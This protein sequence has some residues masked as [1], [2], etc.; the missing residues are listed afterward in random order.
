MRARTATRG[1][2][3]GTRARTR[4][5]VGGALAAA[6]AATLMSTP[7][8]A[9]PGAP[10][11]PA[12][13][14]DATQR[15]LDELVRQGTPGVIA[16]ISS[17]HRVWNGVA[18]VADRATGQPRTANERFRAASI[19]KTFVAAVLLD[20]EADGLLSL[21]DTVEKWLPGVVR[22]NGNDGRNITV[23]QLL[24][25]SSGLRE[26]M[27]DPEYQRKFFTKEFLKSRYETWPPLK[28]VGV[29]LSHRPDFAPGERHS[30]SNTGY[31]LAAMIIEKVSGNSYAG[32]VRKRVLKP[33]GLR[34]TTQ[35]GNRVTIPGPHARMYSALGGDPRT[36]EVYDVTEQNGSQA[37]GDGDV[38]STTGDL[39]RF[40]RGLLGG[41]LLP[42][43]QLAEMKR[44]LPNAGAVESYDSYGLGLYSYRTACGTKVYGHSG[45]AAGGGSEVV[46]TEDGRRS[47]ALNV[48]SDWVLPRSVVDA[49]FCG[50]GRGGTS[51]D[52]KSLDRKSAAGAA[53]SGERAALGRARAERSSTG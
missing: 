8:Q 38:I 16:Q 28:T 1:R 26:Y 21:D 48:N 25:H 46:A 29:G 11:G 5:A 35:P 19:T 44:M 23:R 12:A 30:Y 53:G 50:G 33:L 49:A 32:E 41:E 18:G 20:Q 3:T 10:S 36:D 42:P 9:A 22:G 37:F 27:S 39:N 34:H 52:G 43:R 24:N 7:A 40:L 15:A 14:Y 47:V 31:V 17:G 51:S 6:V 2:T 13:R 4:T 45:G